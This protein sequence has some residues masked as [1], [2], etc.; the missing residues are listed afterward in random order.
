MYSL[1][2]DY[3]QEESSDFRISRNAWISD[4]KKDLDW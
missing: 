2:A 3:K 4:I 1:A